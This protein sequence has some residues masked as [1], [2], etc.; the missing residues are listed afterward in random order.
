MLSSFFEVRWTLTSCVMG[1]SAGWLPSLKCLHLVGHL[2]FRSLFS[3]V[4]T[5]CEPG[6]VRTGSRSS[7][8]SVPANTMLLCLWPH[9]PLLRWGSSL[10]E[11]PSSAP[12]LHVYLTTNFGHSL[13]SCLYTVTHFLHK[14]VRMETQQNRTLSS[15]G[16]GELPDSICQD[17]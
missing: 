9:C 5:S 11:L 4:H 7:C 13:K 3:W 12:V 17:T 10:S 16:E 1:P 8:H 6:G 15:F 2:S 14:V